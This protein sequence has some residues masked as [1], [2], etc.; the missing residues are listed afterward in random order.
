MMGKK[1]SALKLENPG[2]NPTSAT[3][4]CGLGNPGNLPYAQIL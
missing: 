4:L 2:P 3:Y 1:M